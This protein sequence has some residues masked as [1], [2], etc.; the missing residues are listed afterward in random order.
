MNIH[1]SGYIKVSSYHELYY[2]CRGNPN[3]AIILFLHGWP[4]SGCKEKHENNFDADLHNVVFFDQRWAGRSK[5][6]GKDVL[7]ENTTSYLAEDILKILTFLDIDAVHIFWR[8]WWSTL[9]L[10][11]AIEYPEKVISMVIGGIYLWWKPL[12]EEFLYGKGNELF[13]PEKWDKFLSTIP[14]NIKENRKAIFDYIY[15]Q[16]NQW[17]YTPLITVSKYGT[18]LLS[19]DWRNQVSD[20]EYTQQELTGA[21]IGFNYMYHECFMERDY[22]LNNCSKLDHLNISIIQ[23]RYDSVCPCIEAY[24]LHKQL[25]KSTL[26]FVLAWHY[27]SDPEILE[28]SKKEVKRLFI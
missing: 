24:K 23:G 20:S 8:S 9:A 5:I 1:K 15:D 14:D 11:F 4:G 3:G 27:W 16:M 12:E 25:K 13:F 2:E 17:N 6:N 19:L 10:Y 18:E 7:F 21:I 26:H 22:I 28:A